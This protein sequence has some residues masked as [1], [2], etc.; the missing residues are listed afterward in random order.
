MTN[1]EIKL[2]AYKLYQ[3]YLDARRK[4]QASRFW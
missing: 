2:E 4:D 3:M 1:Y